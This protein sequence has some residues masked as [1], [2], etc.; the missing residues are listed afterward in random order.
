MG[1]SVNVFS[2]KEILILEVYF[3]TT[4]LL[5]IY[6]VNSRAELPALATNGAACFDIR[7]CLS[8]VD[9]VTGFNKDNV[10]FEQT[11]VDGVIRIKSGD[12]LMVPT[13]LIFDIPEGYSIRFHPRSGAAL[14]LGL[15]LANAEGVVDW[16]YVEESFILLMNNSAVTQTIPHGERICQAE[17][18]KDQHV[19][20]SESFDRPGQKTNRTGGFGST[21]SK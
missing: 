7:A 13:G 12:R 18:F 2:W 14:K 1:T 6:R 19:I 20:I 10:K 8:G 9:V 11:V 16:D 5:N 17:L 4:P 21:G 15:T 3:M